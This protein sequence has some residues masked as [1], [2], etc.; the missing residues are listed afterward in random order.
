MCV[1]VQENLDYI[2]NSMDEIRF[3]VIPKNETLSKKQKISYKKR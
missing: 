3:G 1:G 2:L